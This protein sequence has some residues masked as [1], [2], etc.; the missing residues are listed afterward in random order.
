[1]SLYSLLLVK[2]ATFNQTL[3]NGVLV[4]A[5]ESRYMDYFSSGVELQEIYCLL[6]P[7]T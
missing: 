7:I 2:I 5:S 3:A 1:M 4:F 6:P